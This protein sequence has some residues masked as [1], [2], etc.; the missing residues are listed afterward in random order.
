MKKYNVNDYMYIQINKNGWEH[1]KK[2]M[3]RKYI[4][5]CIE[6]RK[7]LIDGEVWYK[8]RCHNVFHLFSVN[9]GVRPMFSENVMFDDEAL[10]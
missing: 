6:N 1:L 7:V 3:G 5:Y 10:K 9:F 4:K 2:K 8:L